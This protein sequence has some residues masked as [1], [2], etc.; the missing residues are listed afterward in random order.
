MQRRPKQLR[1]NRLRQGV[2]AQDQLAERLRVAIGE[3]SRRQHPQVAQQ[4]AGFV[5]PQPGL[6][7][8]Q[9][10]LGGD[11]E[12]GGQRHGP[13]Q[14][15][16]ERP[17]R[18]RLRRGQ[19]RIDEAPE[20]YGEQHRGHRQQQ[21][22]QRQERE[23][24]PRGSQ[25]PR[26]R[27]ADADGT[28]RRPKVGRRRE[29]QGDAGEA[30]VE[31]LAGDVAAAG[32]RV[33]DQNVRGGHA[34]DDDE[35]NE[36]EVDDEREAECGQPFRLGSVHLRRQPVVPRRPQQVH[37]TGAVARDAGSPAQLLQRHEAAVVS[38]D[39]R[40]RGDAAF[41]HLRLRDGGRGHPAAAEP[42][43]RKHAHERRLAEWGGRRRPLVETRLL[44]CP[45]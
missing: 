35:M 3:K 41:G 45:S 25:P 18:S 19:R 37:G 38:E 39:D 14:P 16:A 2:P 11:A 6:G 7:S 12:D 28:A 15:Q 36:I 5:A 13:E 9:E 23:R 34:L 44:S 22:D 17:Q 30:L 4:C 42:A 8:P 26:Q 31:V 1:T 10:R 43:E 24:G 29:G 40:Q 20:E 33:V 32:G 21:A 27:P